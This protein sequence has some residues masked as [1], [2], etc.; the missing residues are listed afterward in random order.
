MRE[1]DEEWMNASIRRADR[2]IGK[3]AA[4]AGF[5][6]EDMSKVFQGHEM[7]TNDPAINGIVGTLATAEPASFHPDVLGNQMMADKI[8][9]T[10]GTAISPTFTI[11]P[12]QTITKTFVVEGKRFSVNVGW[13]GS[14]VETTLISPSGIIYSRSNPQDADHANGPT[15]EFYD[16]ANPEPGTW[17]VSSYGLNVAPAGEPVTIEALDES[18]PN[19]APVANISQSGSGAT[20]TYD[21]S[22]SRDPDGSIASYFWDFGDGTSAAGSTVTHTY[23][24]PGQYRAVLVVTD[25]S[26]D[27]GFANAPQLVN[28]AT[29]QDSIVSGGTTSLTNQVT[30]HGTTATTYSNGDLTCDAGAHVEGNVVAVGNIH[31][32]STCH[33]DGNVTAGGNILMDATP[34]VGGDLKATGSLTFQS[35][36]HVLGNVA[37]GSFASL[38]GKTTDQLILAGA[39]NGVVQIGGSIA[40]PAAHPTVGFVYNPSDWPATS[41]LTWRQWVNAAATANGAPTWSHGLGASP[42]CTLSSSADSI[43]GATIT[44]GNSTVVDARKVTS[45]CGNVILQSLTIRLSGD[46]TILADGFQATGGFTVQSADGAPHTLRILISGTVQTCNSS[47]AIVLNGGTNLDAQVAARLHSPGKVS[48]DGTSTVSGQ[49]DAGCI[50]SSG[51]LSFSAVP[52]PTPIIG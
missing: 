24:Q 34:V 17:T 21:G 8:A 11:T 38:D 29:S 18:T 7:C 22:A 33:V 41:Q 31:L 2:A 50:T 1:S 19:V 43:N 5:E 47:S 15:S 12:G 32:T 40:P 27:D 45:N 28:F 13:P 44:V 46:L 26:G 16:I 3:I 10:L 49:I 39:I 6:F 37:A 42:G 9:G 36:A 30:I 14:D 23:L 52:V 51:T 20:I 4:E 25:N 35:T 48:I